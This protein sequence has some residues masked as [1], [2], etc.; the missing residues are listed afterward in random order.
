MGKQ[1]EFE[2]AGGE[3]GIDKSLADTIA[4]PLFHLVRNAVTH[5]IESPNER[6][7]S[8]KSA[9]GKVRLAAYN[10]GSRI[11]IT[12]TDDGRGIDWDRVA[13]AAADHG[14]A[15]SGSDLSTDQCL[16]LI[17]RP[18]FSTARDVSELSGRGIGLDVVDRAMEQAGGEVR[19]A[20][21]RGTGTTFAMIMPATL[22]LVKCLLVQSDGQPYA[23]ESARVADSDPAANHSSTTGSHVNWQGES[24]SLLHLRSLLGQGSAL[25]D[26]GS[27]V[28]WQAPNNSAAV[29]APAGRKRYALVVDGI[30]GHQETLVRSLG[31]HAARWAG[32]CGAAELLDGGVALV[33]DL[34]ELI[35]AQGG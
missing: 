16:R 17:F 30:R 13:S 1:V 4:D 27:V 29:P 3:A 5:G 12:V 10:E 8:G 2:I 23:I 6:V 21:E 18:G 14:I 11:Y 28:V 20:T 34:G 19:V 15:T 33:L 22:A 32:V 7:A 35:K 26:T 31:R 25:E 24:L 9:T